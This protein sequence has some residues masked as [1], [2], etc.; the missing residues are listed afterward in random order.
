[1][2]K[3][4]QDQQKLYFLTSLEDVVTDYLYYDWDDNDHMNRDDVQKLIDDGVVNHAMIVKNFSIYLTKA[5]SE[6]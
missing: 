6:K 2:S 1:M 3:L 4:T 5:L